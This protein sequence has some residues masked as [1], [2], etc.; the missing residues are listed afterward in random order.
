MDLTYWKVEQYR[1]SWVRSL[2]ALELGGDA[3]SCLISSIT[4]PETSNFIFCWPL[5]KSGDIVYVQNSIIFLGE[6]EEEFVPDEPWRFVEPRSTV[7]EDGHEISEWQTTA[8]EVREFLRTV[9][10]S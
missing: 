1:A 7:D 4:N 8:D 9:E 10:S 3:A 6:L 2:K 5:Y